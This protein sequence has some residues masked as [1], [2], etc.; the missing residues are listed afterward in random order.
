MKNVIFKGTGTALITP[1]RE[2]GSINY[3]VFKELIEM[4]IRAMRM[5]LLLQ[6][7][8][9]RVLRLRIKNI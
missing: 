8:Q 5:P 1:M 9:E 4:Q 3:P 7:P 6:G 2:G